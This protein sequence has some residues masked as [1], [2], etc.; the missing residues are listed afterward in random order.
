MA[1]TD[2]RVWVVWLLD[3][4]RYALPLEAVERVVSVPEITPLPQAPPLVCG[5]L[6]VQGRIVPVVDLRRR[7]GLP[8]R[9]L[10]WSDQLVL[11]HSRRRRLAFGVDAVQGLIDGPDDAVVGAAE[12]VPGLDT[13]SGALTLVDGLLLIHD[14]DRLLSLEDERALEASLA[15]LV[16]TPVA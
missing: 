12:I 13:I 8:E 7:F 15:D 4:H 14:L 1:A 6:N 16:G 2:K 10:R 3:G 9:A 5:V 11:A